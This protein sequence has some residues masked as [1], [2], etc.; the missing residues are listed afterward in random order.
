MSRRLFVMSIGPYYTRG[1]GY[2][3]FLLDYD[4]RNTE[5]LPLRAAP[6]TA[7]T[8]TTDKDGRPRVLPRSTIGPTR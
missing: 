6:K 7:P 4:Q 2:K 8:M 5:G 3:R 1:R